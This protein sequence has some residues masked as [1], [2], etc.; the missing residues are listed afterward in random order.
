VDFDHEHPNGI[1]KKAGLDGTE[2]A[3]VGEAPASKL[4][5]ITLDYVRDD[6]YV[7][8][9]EGIR[10]VNLHSLQSRSFTHR[11]HSQ[12]MLAFS[13]DLYHVDRNEKMLKVWSAPANFDKRVPVAGERSSLVTDNDLY[14]ALESD[15]PCPGCR[16]M[17]VLSRPLLDKPLV[18]KCICPDKYSATKENDGGCALSGRNM[19]GPVRT[20]AAQMD[21]WC[22]SDNA[23]M[24]GGKCKEGGYGHR[25]EAKHVTP[26][27]ECNEGFSGLFCEIRPTHSFAQAATS[28]GPVVLLLILIFGSLS[29]PLVFFLLRRN[30][31]WLDRIRAALGLETSK[32]PIIPTFLSPKRSTQPANYQSGQDENILIQT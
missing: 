10:I 12:S 6:L 24:G 17:C 2:I 11:I 16:Y 3:I 21:S 19:D 15:H 25:N 7:Q 22:D 8:E 20:A 23:C 1:I 30:P 31:D 28:K 5:A 13:G 4:K 26:A 18:G 27:C 32:S 9:E 29:I 14:Y